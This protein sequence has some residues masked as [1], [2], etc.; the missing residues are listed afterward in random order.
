MVSGSSQFDSVNE[1][2]VFAVGKYLSHGFQWIRSI[3]LRGNHIWLYDVAKNEWTDA[4]PPALYDRTVQGIDRHTLA[5]MQ[6]ASTY[7]EE[8]QVTYFFGGG[9]YGGSNQRLHYYDAYTNE[10]VKTNAANPPSGRTHAGLSYDDSRDKIYLFGSQNCD[11]TLSREPPYVADEKTWTYDVSTNSWTSADLNPRPPGLHADH[12]CES[13]NYASVAS[14]D[15]D[16]IHDIHVLVAFTSIADNNAGHLGTW[17][18]DAGT[19]TWAQIGINEPD[20]TG[21]TSVRARN[22][23]FSPVDNKFFMSSQYRDIPND[24]Y[25]ENRIWTFRAESGGSYEARPD[26]PTITTDGDSVLVSWNAVPGADTYKIY[27]ATGSIPRTFNEIGE[28]ATP[29]YDD[30]DVTPGTMYYYRITSIDNGVE[31]RQS[32]FARSQPRVMAAPI[33]SARGD[34]DVDIRWTAHSGPDIAGYNIYRGIATIHTNTTIDDIYPDNQ[35]SS[36][37]YDGYSSPVV[38]MVRNITDITRLNSS[39]VT[40]TTY[41]DTTADIDT[42]LPESADYRYAVYAYI[43]KAVNRFGVESG[44]SPYGITIPSAPK[45]VLLNT[46][47]NTIK[48]DAA[49]EDNVIGYNVYQYARTENNGGDAPVNK[50][51]TSLVSSPYTLPSASYHIYDRFWVVPVD[52]LGQEGTPSVPIWYGDRYAG[53]HT[54]DWHQ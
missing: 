10:L 29:S 52:S 19:S 35:W 22:L 14:M 23:H 31:S 27:R 26:A 1:V 6:V 42:P 48:W 4:L 47:T 15:Y 46:K 12:T 51:N 43:I 40:G 25:P 36:T 53:Y 37:L 33:V 16:P 54:G 30:T 50:V 38:T 8:H 28:T 39:L 49:V 18:Y 44:S 3:N 17:S 5:V 21:F 13:D 24:N 20:A 32:F 41:R 9:G 2:A 34:Y 45:N 11:L 7:A